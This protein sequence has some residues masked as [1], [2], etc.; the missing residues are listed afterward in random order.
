V[1]RF[2]Q[3]LK[4]FLAKQAPPASLALL[5]LQL[6]SFRAYY[7]QHRPHRAV[8]GQ[9][10]L[11]AFSAGLKAGP[12]LPQTSTHF[13]LRHDKVDTT[14]CVT[15]RSL[16]RLH[17]ICLGR[18]HAGEVVRLLVANKD[19]RVM[20]EDGPLIRQLTLDPSRDYQARGLSRPVLD[21]VR[22]VSTMY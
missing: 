11:V 8:H 4:R 1:E 2:H 12:A 14:G 5:Q 13:R 10:P 15:V 17:H 6:D 21:D 9:T 18:A 19:I 3:T 16:S 22:H 7:N 20:R